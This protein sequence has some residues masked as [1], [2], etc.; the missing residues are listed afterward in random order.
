M[1]NPLDGKGLTVEPLKQLTG[2]RST[3]FRFE[4]NC[5]SVKKAQGKQSLFQACR[6]ASLYK[7][8]FHRP[9]NSQPEL[10]IGSDTVLFL[11]IRQ[12]N[13]NQKNE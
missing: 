6:S 5:P 13:F 10:S 12:E 9:M 11:L 4:I 8:G 7:A 2:E 1:G 3:T